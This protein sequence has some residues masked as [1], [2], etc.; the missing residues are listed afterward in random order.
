MALWDCDTCQNRLLRDEAPN[1]GLHICSRILNLRKC[2]IPITFL[3]S[4]KF[5][6]EMQ[7]LHNLLTLLSPNISFVMAELMGFFSV[8]HISDSVASP[9]NLLKAFKLGKMIKKNTKK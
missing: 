4:H 8:V 7:L 9:A 3:V 1:G 2:T 5:P 6:H